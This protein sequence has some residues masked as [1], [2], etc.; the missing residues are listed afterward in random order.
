MFGDRSL[1]GLGFGSL[2][3]WRNIIIGDGN[4]FLRFEKLFSF[5]QI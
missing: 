1:V 5:P 2:E 4:N 3:A